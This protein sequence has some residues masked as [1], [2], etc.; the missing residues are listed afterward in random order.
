MKKTG[1]GEATRV[2][3]V[4][5]S[6]FE[7][8]CSRERDLLLAKGFQ[9]LENPYERPLTRMEMLKV[10]PD[11]DAAFVGLEIW[12]EEL[13]SRAGKL[14]IISRW[15]VGLDNIDLD[16]ARR[17]GVVVTRAVRAN[18][19]SVAEHSITLMLAALRYLPFYDRTTKQGEWAR[20]MGDDLSGKTV[21]LAGFGSIGRLVAGMLSGFKVHLLAFDPFIDFGKCHDLNVEPVDLASLCKRSDIISLHIPSMPETR[22]IIGAAELS[23]M[24]SNAIVINT[25]RG[26][27]IDEKA[28]YAALV[29]SSIR[30]AGLDVFENEP[31]TAANPLLALE[32]VVVT[33]HVAGYSLSAF[34][35][36][37]RMVT[38]AV[39]DF[40][41]GHTPDNIVV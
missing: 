25:S 35:E 6:H 21:G 31:V 12:D 18:S 40:F 22:H 38:T 33:P 1:G 32:N 2:L 28:L 26:T 24:K 10:A 20:R 30:G 14:K 4:A 34:A 3:L 17:H 15:G 29:S 8:Y 11:I 16:A 37:S 27:L 19:V 23:L 9:L 5:S 41:E 13:F 36:T 39:L 7:E